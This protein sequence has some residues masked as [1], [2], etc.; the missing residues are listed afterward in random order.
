MVGSSRARIIGQAGKWAITWQVCH[1]SLD[2]CFVVVVHSGSLDR[3]LK[4]S[5]H[6]TVPHL[7]CSCF[8]A[9]S[10]IV[11]V[12]WVAFPIRSTVSLVVLRV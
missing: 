4:S 11:S 8:L 6:L 2:V 5:G 12:W 3:S 9:H 7:H 10:C 1:L